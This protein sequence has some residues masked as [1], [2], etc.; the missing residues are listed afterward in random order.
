MSTTPTPIPSFADDLVDLDHTSFAVH[1]AMGWGRR[2]RRDLGATP[3]VGEALSEF[4]YLLLYV[5]TVTDGAR[6]ELIEPTGPGFLQRNLDKRGEGP[7][8]I[9]FTVPDLRSAVNHVRALGLSVVGESYEHPPWREAFIMPDSVHGVV[10]QLA[11]SDSVYP[12]P[13]ELLS[14]RERAFEDVPSP[15][16]ATDP[17]W[18]AEIWD[19][20]RTAQ[21]VLGPTHVGSTDLAAS[22][23][24]FA[25]VL[26]AETTEEQDAI[27]FAWPSG[28]IRVENT[29]TAGVLG[30][31]LVGGNVDDMHIGSARLGAFCHAAPQG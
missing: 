4:R 27:E 25:D 11:Q 22:R 23:R 15:A 31:T 30:M 19:V 9:T 12:S 14:S 28:S 17:E 6:I 29:E 21:A 24:L 2:L 26:G 7:H 5:G 20:E 13:E 8:H 10:I 18:W 1:D 16:D 3:I